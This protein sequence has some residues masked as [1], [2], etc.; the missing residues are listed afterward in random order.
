MENII[1]DWKKGL[2]LG[3][4]FPNADSSEALFKSLRASFLHLHVQEGNSPSRV[5]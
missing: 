1:E 5:I 2:T 4:T 3:V